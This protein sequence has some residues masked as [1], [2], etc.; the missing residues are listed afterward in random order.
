MRFGPGRLTIDWIPREERQT[1]TEREMVE[2]HDSYIDERLPDVT[3]RTTTNV[4][5]GT[6]LTSHQVSCVTLLITTT[7]TT[8]SLMHDVRCA[9]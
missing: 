5:V 9:L 2:K 6:A 3:T 4:G 1:E 7:I 8:T